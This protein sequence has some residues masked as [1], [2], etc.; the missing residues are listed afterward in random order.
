M[1]PL[2][3]RDDQLTEW[4]EA[5]AN[6]CSMAIRGE[7]GIG[8]SRLLTEFA[9]IA[10]DHGRTV[11]RGRALT[12]A[13]LPVTRRGWPELPACYRDALGELVPEWRTGRP[14]SSDVQ[15]EAVARLLHTVNGVLILDGASA[16]P[17]LTAS[18]VVVTSER[19]PAGSDLLP[20]LADDASLALIDALHGS[21]S[22]LTRAEGLPLAIVELCATG[23]SPTLNAFT[24]AALDSAG[25][26][27]AEVAHAVA[28]AEEAVA[29]QD[30]QPLTSLDADTVA[31]AL[32]E[33]TTAGLLV[34][35]QTHCFR[36]GLIREAVLHRASPTRAARTRV[37]L[38][39][40]LALRSPEQAAL[41]AEMALTLAPSDEIRA[42]AVDALTSALVS[43]GRFDEAMTHL[44]SSVPTPETHSRAARCAV[45]LG[46][47]TS[48]A[49]HLLA[50]VPDG[51]ELLLDAREAMTGDP[52]DAVEPLTQLRSLVCWRS[53]A[54]LE[55][56]V[57]DCLTVASPFRLQHARASAHG[58]LLSL[59]DHH[60]WT[61]AALS[62]DPLGPA[63]PATAELWHALLAAD[64]AG[65]LHY[66]G[67]LTSFPETRGIR[68]LLSF[69]DHADASLAADLLDH[70]IGSW[71]NRGL[72]HLVFGEARAW[73]DLDRTPLLAAMGATLTHDVARVTPAHG[74]FVSLGNDPWRR[75]CEKVMREAGI[76]IPRRG[77]G[78]AQ[79]PP[80]L[81]AF[82]VTSREMD[83][84]LLIAQGTT[85]ADIAVKLSVSRRTVDT[86]VRNLLA[87]TGSTR[88]TNLSA[89]V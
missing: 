52:A 63:A 75:R 38:S 21:P 11:L 70:G 13:L 51:T 27:A 43:L 79:V 64:L 17:H 18:A 77:R 6:G 47:H 35:G 67:A 22:L 87:K 24:A 61:V 39:R 9:R 29:W 45:E 30:V 37:L 8:K 60:L 41:A 83:V 14:V 56:G 32:H 48:A 53:R 78:D 68:A 36:H 26:A 73:D 12:D 31:A 84:L 69:V 57:V 1:T 76:P 59:A 66:A 85:N 65:A 19:A 88:R 15:A 86:H 82:G 89:L 62:G 71:T 81:R 20:R 40:H 2:F 58:T 49:A 7:T 16:H 42:A 74:T 33:L 46:D 34:G 10:S 28:V 5:L 55:L 50:G 25:P 80:H 72:A 54:E 44:S 23:T 4:R 3:G